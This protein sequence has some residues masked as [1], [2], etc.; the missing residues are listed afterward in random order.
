MP[1]WRQVPV[2]PAGVAG[3]RQLHQSPFTTTNTL[4]TNGGKLDSFADAHSCTAVLQKLHDEC[5]RGAKYRSR[6]LESLG[7]EVKMANHAEGKNPVVMGRLGNNPD[8]PTV[9]FYGHYD[10]QVG[11][12]DA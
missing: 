3:W 1:A 10:V 8:H 7:A 12:S 2:A 4:N 9:A 6:L 5:L 11:I